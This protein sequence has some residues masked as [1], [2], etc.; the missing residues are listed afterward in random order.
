[1]PRR[2]LT[3]QDTTEQSAFARWTRDRKPGETLHLM[4]TAEAQVIR[5]SPTVSERAD[6]IVAL[7]GDAPTDVRDAAVAEA[8]RDNDG[9]S[10]V[11]ARAV[12]SN[13]RVDSYDTTLN[14]DGWERDDFKRNPVV[15]F[16]HASHHLPVGRDLGTFVRDEGNRALMG[17]T[18]FVGEKLGAQEAKV[19]RWVAAGLLNATSVG[20]EPIESVYAEDRDTGETFWMP[21]DFIRQRL[22]E[23]SW[24]PVPA[25]A[26]CL[27]DGRA[28]RSSGVD[29]VELRAM[30]E[31][32]LDSADVFYIPRRTL[33]EARR[34]L[35]PATITVEV[36]GLGT[37]DVRDQRADLV[38]PNCEYT[39]PAEDFAPADDESAEQGEAEEPASVD[40]TEAAGDDA[41]AREVAGMVASVIEIVTTGRLP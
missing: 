8:E 13:Q 28:L 15:L 23:Y 32:A 5:L 14:V 35:E 7:Y 22:R 3:E 24:V 36:R 25:N 41:E 16:A 19:G 40:E 17:V 37:F 39:G 33:L 30:L 29:P 20:F 18:R 4:H 34:A 26:D 21:I 10:D 6:Q 2:N 27:V 9:M 11:V 31:E 1:M 12:I 38:C